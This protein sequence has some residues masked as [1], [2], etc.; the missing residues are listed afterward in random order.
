MGTISINFSNPIKKKVT[1]TK[2][3]PKEKIILTYHDCIQGVPEYYTYID[4][5]GKESVF[6]DNTYIINKMSSSKYVAKKNIV[7]KIPLTYIPAKESVEYQPSYYTYNNGEYVYLD[8]VIYDEET[9]SYK[10]ILESAVL[11]HTQ[12]TLFEEEK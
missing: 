4:E 2:E 1:K 12:I 5:N 11:D 8:K 7:N 6:K 3:Q 10:G 9:N